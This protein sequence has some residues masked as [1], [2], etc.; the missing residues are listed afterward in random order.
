VRVFSRT[1]AEKCPVVMQLEVCFVE[2]L[3]L[4]KKTQ[5]AGLAERF[6]KEIVGP[7]LG[8]DCKRMRLHSELFGGSQ[9][10]RHPVRRSFLRF[11][12]IQIFDLRPMA[13]SP[14]TVMVFEDSKFNFVESPEYF[15]A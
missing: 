13:E 1:P 3:K 9:T 14:L 8:S 11:P 15:F 6:G 7:P 2:K 12:K 4:K 10:K 5:P